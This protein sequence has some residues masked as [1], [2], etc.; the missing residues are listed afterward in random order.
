MTG[1]VF[2]VQLFH[3]LLHGRYLA[4]LLIASSRYLRTVE[5]NL[6]KL[7][8]RPVLIVW[9]MKDFAFRDTERKRFERAFPRHKTV[10]LA[11]ASHF[12]QEDAGE[13]IVEEIKMFLSET[14]QV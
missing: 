4:H 8:D 13:Q 5:E 6:P 9:G 12:L 7:A 11:N 14:A 2:S 3:L 10:M 1:W